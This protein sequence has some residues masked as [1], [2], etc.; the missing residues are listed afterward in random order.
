MFIALAVGITVALAALAAYFTVRHQ[1]YS[2]V[3]SALVTEM[4]NSPGRGGSFNINEVEG[5]LARY[6]NSVLQVID[7][8]GQ[9]RYPF[10]PGSSLP[11]TASQAGMVGTRSAYSI[12]TVRT[13]SGPYRVI[14]QGGF[15]DQNGV[16]VAIQIARPLSDINHTLSDLRLILW[17]VTLIGVGVSIVMGYL[18]GRATMRPVKKLTAAAEHVAATQ[19][20]AST[21][22]EEGD[23][24]LARLARSFNSMLAALG[25]SRQQQVQLISD[26]GHE[27][28]TPLTSLRTNI[29]VLMRQPNL[30]HGDRA[31]LMADVQAQL[32]ELTTLIGDVVELARDDERRIEPIEVRFDA[33]VEHAIERA[34]RRAP[35]IRFETHVTAGSVRAQPAL[36]ERAVLNVLDNAVKWSPPESPVYVSLIRAD[37]W[38]LE[39][40]DHG[41]GIA[42][43]DLP[44][45]FDRFYRADAA[46]AMPGSGLGLAIVR[47]V[48]MEHGGWVSASSPDGGGTLIHIELPIVA[49][50]EPEAPASNGSLA[51]HPEAPQAVPAWPNAIIHE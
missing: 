25:A 20:L 39:V 40:R 19:D 34:R 35:A 31:E 12:Q 2:D 33:I 43:D 5:F 17:L 14:T 21:I 48:I 44:R 46:R 51:D 30:P 22:S 32:E 28:R 37:R 15:V 26:A 16:P 6:T 41:P 36:L 29:E 11:V 42:A 4:S 50:T 18:L 47:Q 27:L 10:A 7:G 23:D 1:L 13:G 24:E 45:V 38:V 9:V 8:Q 49:E 3:D